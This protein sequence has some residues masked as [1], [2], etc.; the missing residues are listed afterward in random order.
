MQAEVDTDNFSML[1]ITVPGKAQCS[2]PISPPPYC[3]LQCDFQKALEEGNQN[4][5]NP[6]SLLLEAA[7][8]LTW[9][10]HHLEW[11]A[12]GQP[13]Q[14]TDNLLQCLPD[15]LGSSM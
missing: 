13:G 2:F 6:I 11:Q 15:G 1:S 14:T 5:E 10:Q 8:E 7:E 3:S 4:Y 12:Y 9:W